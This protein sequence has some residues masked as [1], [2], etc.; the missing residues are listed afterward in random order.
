MRRSAVLLIAAALAASGC[1]SYAW[2]PC[3]RRALI[4]E[5]IEVGVTTAAVLSDRGEE[6]NVVIGHGG[7][8]EV[9]ASAALVKVAS[10]ALIR[11]WIAH[12][13][14]LDAASGRGRDARL[15]CRVWNVDS[16]LNV[17]VTAANSRAVGSKRDPEP[18]PP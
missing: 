7:S 4:F 12:H 8:A 16:A 14:A 6:L 9:V 13:D 11:R 2:Q 1:A 15:L 17:A 3:E 18:S 5:A 10:H